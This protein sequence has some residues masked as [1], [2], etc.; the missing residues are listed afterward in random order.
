MT[1]LNKKSRIKNENYLLIQGWMVNEL[2][3]KGNE[4]LIYAI[5]YGF[6]QTEN[7]EFTGSLQ[8]LA[9]WTQSTKQGVIK[10][11]K[12]LLSK[13]LISKK[14]TVINN[15]KFCK[16]SVNTIKQSLT[17]IKQ[18]LTD[19]IKLSLPNNKDLYNKEDN[20]DKKS[21]KT[22]LSEN[23]TPSKETVDKLKSEGYP[24]EQIN[25]TLISFKDYWLDGDGKGKKKVNWQSTFRNW[26]RRQKAWKTQRNGASFDERKEIEDDLFRA[27]QIIKAREGKNV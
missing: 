27:E 17:G 22:K 10:A 3:L 16:Y 14:E 15:I 11:I 18:S 4:L 1:H 24:Q 9:D 8:Y 21:Q 5:I 19:G 26:V 7:Q 2:H 25:K 23:F 6:S 13:N 12:K 20:K